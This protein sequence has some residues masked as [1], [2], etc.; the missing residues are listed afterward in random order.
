MDSSSSPPFVDAANVIL[1]LHFNVSKE[2][3]KAWKRPPQ[4]T[5]D[6]YPD[7]QHNLPEN[8]C[9]KDDATGVQRRFRCNACSCMIESVSALREHVAGAKH[10]KNRAGF[11]PFRKQPKQEGHQTEERSR[12]RM[13][14]RARRGKKASNNIQ[15]DLGE[16]LRARVDAGEE[17]PPL[18]GLDRVQEFRPASE[19]CG[20]T[21]TATNTSAF[22]MYKCGLFHCDGA[23]GTSQAFA[24]H[25]TSAKHMV[26]YFQVGKSILLKCFS[27]LT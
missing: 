20:V 10:A 8:F 6:L 9:K 26:N 2:G 18:V 24:D 12:E 13:M 7:L 21:T 22:P 27:V 11:D 23:W 14:K 4:K 1:A 16:V 19:V 5:E 17:L 25:V 15:I 3:K